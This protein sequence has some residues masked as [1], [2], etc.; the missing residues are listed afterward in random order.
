MLNFNG[1]EPKEIRYDDGIRLPNGYTR[2]EYIESTGTQYIDTGIK[3]SQTTSCLIKNNFN[4]LSG[5]QIFG[6]YGFPKRFH[7][8][9]VDN[10]VYMP[11]VTNGTTTEHTFQANTNVHT[12]FLSPNLYKYDNQEIAEGNF[13]F[14]KMNFYLF[15]RN[16]NDSVANYCKSKLY[17]AKFYDNNTLIRNFI[18]ARRNSDN[19]LGLY[20]TVND[21]FYTNQGTGSFIAGNE[22]KGHNVAKVVY[23]GTVVWKGLPSTYTRL[24]YIESTGTQY[25]DTEIIADN[26]TGFLV[27]AQKITDNGTD[28]MIIGSRVDSGNT[29]CWVD[30]DGSGSPTISNLILGWGNLTNARYRIELNYN[31][32]KGKFNY[33]NDR[34]VYLNGELNNSYTSQLNDT[35]PNQSGNLFICGANYSGFRY[36]FSGR[37]YNIQ[38]TKGNNLV[39]NFIPARRNSDNEVGLY[40]TV[41]EQFYTNQGTGSFIAGEYNLAA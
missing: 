4:E 38:I 8:G 40:D 29:R 22:Y 24:E 34:K 20:D 31:R 33:Y 19:E 30:F 15:A 32:F 14:P 11:T 13:D 39:R 16:N 21:V 35:L 12:Y 17:F 25:I 26:E 41:T 2:L 36:P 28:Q 37:V 9:I 1:N 10:Q 7:Y 3:G 5:T 6:A 27:D 23:N 18:P